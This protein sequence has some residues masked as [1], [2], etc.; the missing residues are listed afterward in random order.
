MYKTAI[1]DLDGTLMNTLE[2]LTDSLNFSLEKNGFSKRTTDE[3]RH[4]LGNGYSHLI[5]SALPDGA[6]PA[7]RDKVLSDFQGH[8]IA[9]CENKTK[10][11]DGVC[12][13]L[14]KLSDA[15]VKLCIVSNKNDEAVKQLRDKFFPSV[16][17][18]IG[19]REGVK[20]KPAP[21]MVVA[22]L[23]ELG[24]DRVNSVYVGDSEVD[25]LTAENSGVPCISVGWGFRT[26]EELIS[27]GAQKIYDSVDEVYRAIVL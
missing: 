25:I 14:C 7:E 15:K 20:R 16:N 10:P 27:A 8:Y 3:V 12:E 18:A 24:E 22:A 1:F 21:D 17:V 6:T 11:Y 13:M 5:N 23:E 19:E 4:F 2:D 26:H 9:N